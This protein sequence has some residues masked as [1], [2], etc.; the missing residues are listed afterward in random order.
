MEST[1]FTKTGLTALVNNLNEIINTIS[2]E[3]CY[4]QIVKF[5]ALTSMF[6]DYESDIRKL[7]LKGWE[8]RGIKS[9]ARE[10]AEKE[11]DFF[12][13][14][15]RKTGR[16]SE[17]NRTEAW[18]EVS[19]KVIYFRNISDMYPDTIEHFADSD[20]ADLQKSIRKQIVGYVQFYKNTFNVG[21]VK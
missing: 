20:N 18:E 11:R 19:G 8:F 17:H 4:S 13:Q 9:A 14:K 1:I 3:N 16:N 12:F 10:K 6:E 5:F 15:I 7:P 21:W 2:D